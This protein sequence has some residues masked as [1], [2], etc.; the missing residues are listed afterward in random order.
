MISRRLGRAQPTRRAARPRAGTAASTSTTSTPRRDGGLLDRRG[1]AAL[2][3][4]GRARRG[5]CRPAAAAAA[6]PSGSPTS[7]ESTS[8]RSA[9]E[10]ASGPIVDQCRRA[11]GWTCGRCPSV[12]TRPTPGRIPAIAAEVGRRA[13]RAAVVR[14]DPERRHARRH[15]RALAAARA[16]GRPRRV[17]RVPGRAVDEVRRVRVR[18][19][20]GDVRLA[21]QDRPGLAQPRDRGRVRAP[22]ISTRPQP[23]GLARRAAPRRRSPP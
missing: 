15:R 22:A 2:D 23:R 7:T 12:G 10:R 9:T 21:D 1:A 18:A 16:A 20:L 4:A 14:A 5:R 17:D 6:P 3:A 19:E 8:S 13:D 11:G